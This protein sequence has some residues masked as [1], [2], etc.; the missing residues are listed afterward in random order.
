V[1]GAQLPVSH[2][3][4]GFEGLLAKPLRSQPRIAEDW[5]LPVPGACQVDPDR[6]A[7][8]PLYEIAEVRRRE[9]PAEVAALALHDAGREVRRRR[10]LLRREEAACPRTLRR[11]RPNF[12]RRA[13]LPESALLK[14]VKGMAVT[15]CSPTPTA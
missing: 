2:E 1:Q 11:R 12:S 3:H 5:A 7:E 15:P 13:V 8:H 9:L 10:G 4:S 6:V 14:D